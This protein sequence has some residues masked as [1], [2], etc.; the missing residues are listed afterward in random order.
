MIHFKEIFWNDFE[1]ISD[2]YAL[3]IS[4]PRARFAKV[5]ETFWVLQN[6]KSKSADRSQQTRQ[7][8]FVN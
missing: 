6:P 2:F 4:D 7:L 3:E 1:H 5:P 8:G